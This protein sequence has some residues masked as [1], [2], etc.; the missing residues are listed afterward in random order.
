MAGIYK[1]GQTYW[2]RAQRNGREFRESLKTRDRRVAEKR[3]DAWKAK[4]EALAWGDRPRIT[5]TEAVKA[6]FEEHVPNLKPSS[7]RRYAVS[8]KN[9]AGTFEG[10]FIDQIDKGSLNEFETRRRSEGASAPTVRR[11]LA[12]L[13]SVLALCE[14]KD[15][16]DE[17]RNPV[18]GYMRNRV[19]RGLKEADPRKR[20]LSLEEEQALIDHASPSV[21]AAVAIAIDTGLRREEMFSLTWSQ[22]DRKKM[23]IWTTTDT[24]SRKARAVPLS[25]R[26]AHLSAQLKDNQKV[27]SVHVF[28]HEDGTRLQQC[29]KGFRAAARRATKDQDKY[30][31]V[32]ITDI[33][34]HDLR[35]TAGCRWLQRDQLRMEEVSVLLG[36]S[37]V[38]VTSRV[39]AFL[40]NETVATSVSQAS[41]K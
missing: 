3:Y 5:F 1:R 9:L 19:K 31:N 13:S 36:H 38:L 20:Y 26:A 18:R 27:A 33:R 7:A 35:R 24:K 2:A 16:I 12:C 14:D 15:W 11:D 8:L 10:K 23:V 30:K 21:A 4:L 25:Q 32:Q 29:D 6:F 34:W 28:T 39:Y 17:G 37:S 41:I 40:E 22:I